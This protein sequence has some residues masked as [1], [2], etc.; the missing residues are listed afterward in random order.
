MS[1][2]KGIIFSVLIAA[3]LISGCGNKSE[4]DKQNQTNQQKTQPDPKDQYRM[5]EMF[6]D[7]KNQMI[8]LIQGKATFQ[9]VYEGA[10]NF[11]AKVLNTDGTELAI[12]ADVTGNY[13]GKKTIDVPLTTAY[14]LDVHCKGKWSVYR[15]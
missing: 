15:E 12:L 10:G 4:K 14:I 2:T 5:V 7:D 8:D 1:K 9:I 11:K 3:A 13:K 6:D